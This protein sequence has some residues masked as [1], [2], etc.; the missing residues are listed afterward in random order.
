M[1]NLVDKLK[2]AF[3]SNFLTY[4]NAHVAHWNVV[5]PRFSELHGLFGEIYE[6]AHAAVD[7][8]AEFLRQ[9]DVKVSPILPAP[10]VIGFSNENA[11]TADMIRGLRTDA[12]K[13]ILL[14]IDLFE[15][16]TSEGENALA[17]FAADRQAAHSKF[18]WKL[19]STSA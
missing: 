18:R 4:W 6:D 5:D 19:R 3:N 7:T 11:T 17:N 12:E 13:M 2:E 14:S 16:A 15:L 8:Y 10:G 9:L 1:S